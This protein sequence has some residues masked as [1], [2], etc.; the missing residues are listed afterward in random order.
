MTQYLQGI[1]YSFILS[2]YFRKGYQIYCCNLDS[3]EFINA[4]DVNGIY[5]LLDGLHNCI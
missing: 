4:T 1:P 5:E 3:L 2:V